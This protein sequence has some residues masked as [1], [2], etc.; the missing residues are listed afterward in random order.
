MLRRFS[1]D[2]AIFS[3][4]FDCLLIAIA[5]GLAILFRPLLSFIP[6]AVDFKGPFNIPFSLYPTFSISWML[7]LV[8]FSVYDARRNFRA[9]DELTSLTFGSLLA[10]VALAGLLY[11]TYRDIS[12]ALYILFVILAFLL[13][14]SYR[15]IY[16]VSF[17]Y[18]LLNSIQQRKVLIIGHGPVGSVIEKHLFEQRELG[19]HLVGY[20]DD[21][22]DKKTQHPDILGKV[23]DA[24]TIILKNHIDDLVLAL[25]RRAYERTN[26]LV[27]VLS[28]L[29]IK[30]WV[31]PDYF[32]LVLSRASVEEF[33][34]MPLIDLRAPSL[35]D[36]Q[37][38]IKR[39]FD[40]C[41]SLLLMPFLL[42]PMAIIALAI[43]LD[44]PGPIIFKQNR[45][46]ENGRMFGMYKF[47]SMVTEA[48]SMRHLI[49]KRDEQGNIIQNKSM[50]D[51]RITRVGAVIRK[52]SLD[53]LPQI[54]NVLYGDMSIV[55]PRPELPYMV[56]CY[57]PWQR[58]RFTVPQGITGWWQV[59]G[60]S[61]KPMYQNTEDDLYYIQHYSFWLDIWI[62]VKTVGAVVNRK[63]A[64]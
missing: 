32:T 57:E 64:Y 21:D 19:L 63:G 8:L 9:V 28:D 26:E 55:G 44:S 59:N 39:I 7:I 47:R 3:M 45:V 40:I 50:Q 42:P 37:R 24:R 49:E 33:A 15:I 48:E 10:G 54:F 53:E 56:E 30:I 35:S 4:F 58:K 6:W 18:G 61:D 22:P 2:F 29:P 5:L 46:G 11:L 27:S 17:R 14:V 20:L 36:Y 1:I 60:R 62:L 16:R 38:L 25:P 43:R 41:I 34:G 51:P 23:D 52:L 12:R 31:I 13:L